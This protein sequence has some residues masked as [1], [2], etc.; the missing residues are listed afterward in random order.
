MLSAFIATIIAVA[1]AIVTVTVLWILSTRRQLVVLEENVGNAMSQIGVQLSGCMDALMLLLEVG[2]T[3]DTRESDLLMEAVRSGRKTITAQSTPE[4]VIQQQ[5]MISET[6]GRL[7]M[8]AEQSPPLEA[9]PTFVRNV[10]AIHAFEHM[11]RTSR[12]IYNDSVTKLNREIRLFPVSLIARLM[13]FRQREYLEDRA[14]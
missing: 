11:L 10:D 6:L 13:G 4:D 7:S 12:L 3:V 8:L 14:G 1:A 5:A 9:D 2:K